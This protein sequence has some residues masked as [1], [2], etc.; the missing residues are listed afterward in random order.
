MPRFRDDEQHVGVFAA[1]TPDR[2]AL[3]DASDGSVVT[4]AEYE[5]LSN[6]CAHMLRAS[7]L[8]RGDGV[9]VLMENNLSY[10]PF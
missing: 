2:P 9:A 8:R 10:F 6:R 3:I 4:F 1:R 7:G 5:A